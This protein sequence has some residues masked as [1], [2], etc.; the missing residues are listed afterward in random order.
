[1]E[2]ISDNGFLRFEVDAV[3]HKATLAPQLMPTV[4]GVLLVA[5]SDAFPSEGEPERL[6]LAHRNIIV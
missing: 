2:C 6:T 1:M 4:D 5:D 3:W